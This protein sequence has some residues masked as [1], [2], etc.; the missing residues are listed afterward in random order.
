MIRIVIDTNILVSALLQPEGPPAAVFM[1]ALSP[2]VKLCISGPV[3]EEYEEVICRPRFKRSP[4]VIEKTLADIRQS[5][6]WVR[7]GVK[8][9]VC[10]DPDDNIFLECAVAA[11]AH[12]LV[13]G[14][15]KDFPG[16]WGQTRVVTAREFLDVIADAAPQLLRP[17]V[18]CFIMNKGP[19]AVCARATAAGQSL[20][21]RHRGD[22]CHVHGG[23]RHHRGQRVVAAHRR[24]PVG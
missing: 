2:L 4:E 13:T 9:E 6:D 7:P 1:L 12:Y 16:H 17:P 3:Y 18:S 5:G 20:D 22:V 15:R 21:R 8:L 19:D 14:N 23:A 24:Q 11:E 10:A